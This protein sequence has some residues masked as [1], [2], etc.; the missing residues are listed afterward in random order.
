MNSEID[1]L[2][3]DSLP[4]GPRSARSTGVCSA[5]HMVA[6]DGGLAL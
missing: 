6:T 2:E 5:T 3:C 4:V 1:S